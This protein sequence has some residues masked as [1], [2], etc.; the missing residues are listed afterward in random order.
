[1]PIIDAKP[2]VVIFASPNSKRNTVSQE[3][4]SLYET[5]QSNVSSLSEVQ[6][7]FAITVSSFILPTKRD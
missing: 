2:N 4:F 1:M 6:R 5:L 7:Q 3:N